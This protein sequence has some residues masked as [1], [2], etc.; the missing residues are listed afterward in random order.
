M[1]PGQK[2]RAT[3]ALC[4]VGQRLFSAGLNGEITEY[5]LDTLRPR[6]SVSAYGGPVW[7]I[8]GNPQGTLLTVS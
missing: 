2:G 5:D 3:D 6:Y 8:S 7:A 1:V 4:W